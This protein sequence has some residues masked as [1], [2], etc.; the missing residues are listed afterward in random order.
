MA[1]SGAANATSYT[2]YSDAASF[3]AAAP[4]LVTYAF[5]AGDDTLEA[6]P[7][8]DG[9]LGF[10]TYQH[11]THPYLENDGAF[12]AGQTYLAMIGIPGVNAVMD[13]LV[14]GMYAVAFD[15]G[16]YDGGDTVS[17]TLNN[18][19]YVETFQTFGVGSSTFVGVVSSDPIFRINFTA[20]DG[21]QLDILDFTT[22]AIAAPVPEPA[23]A[24]LALAGLGF[25]GLVARR[26]KA[27]KAA[28]QA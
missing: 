1:A 14:D 19:D 8:I 5:P 9:P 3:A 4:G 17:L 28:A 21:T 16:T 25:L 6:R 20:A 26:R 10:S 18:S 15:I 7:Y 22:L 11:F 24:S 23:P 2:T 12:G 27:A 13:A